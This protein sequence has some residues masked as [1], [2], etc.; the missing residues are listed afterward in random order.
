MDLETLQQVNILG[1]G[2]NDINMA[3]VLETIEG[4]IARQEPRYAC[5]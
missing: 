3:M 5:W 2:V 1:I 4:W